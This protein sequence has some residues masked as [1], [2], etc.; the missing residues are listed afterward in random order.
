[1]QGRA[2]ARDRDWDLG[3]SCY[4][5]TKHQEPLFKSVRLTGRWLVTASAG[6]PQNRL[7]DSA[8][9]CGLADSQEPLFKKGSCLVSGPI[10]SD[11]S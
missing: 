11:C 1:M 10:P 6:S 8:L 9:A 3:N 4:P 7:S 5:R 2:E